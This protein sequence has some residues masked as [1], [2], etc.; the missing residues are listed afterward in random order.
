ME[1]SRLN[2]GFFKQTTAF[3]T[4]IFGIIIISTMM[5]VNGLHICQAFAQWSSFSLLLPLPSA[6]AAASA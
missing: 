1:T 3:S 2:D 4:I 6:T 5:I